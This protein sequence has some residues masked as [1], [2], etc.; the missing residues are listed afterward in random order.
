[1]VAGRLAAAVLGA[2]LTI[3]CGG[4]SSSPMAAATPAPAGVGPTVLDGTNFDA[5][6]LAS[7]RSCLVEFQRPT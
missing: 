2:A 7:G 3:A 6:V 5:L 1:M 4:S